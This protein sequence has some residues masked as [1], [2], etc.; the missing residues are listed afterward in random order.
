MKTATLPPL[1]VEPAL[2]AQVEQLLAPGETLST[3]VEQAI[4]QSIE[5]RLADAA[6]AE[7]A[8][9]ARDASRA[10]GRYYSAASVLR[11]LKS[12]TSAARRRRET[13]G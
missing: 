2:R 12:R 9:A 13:R 11:D 5:L 7:R 4:R 1:R 6:F 10:S 8:L 3:F